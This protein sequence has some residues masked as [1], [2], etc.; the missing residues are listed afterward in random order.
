VS[1]NKNR[2]YI[3]KLPLPYR[4]GGNAYHLAAKL[5][6]RVYAGNEK[7]FIV[8]RPAASFR[9]TNE[10]LRDKISYINTN[11]ECVHPVFHHM[12]LI[13]LF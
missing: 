5:D 8:R 10:E 6:L 11:S 13:T 12:T 2:F 3:E 1:R 9:L 7:L 4:C